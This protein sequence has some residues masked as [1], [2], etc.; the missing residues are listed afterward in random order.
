MGRLQREEQALYRICPAQNDCRQHRAVHHAARPR[1]GKR[2][3]LVPYLASWRSLARLTEATSESEPNSSSSVRQS[4]QRPVAELV[5]SLSLSD[6]RS[7][8]RATGSA[9]LKSPEHRGS[10]GQGKPVRDDAHK[11][12]IRRA[13]NIHSRGRSWMRLPPDQSRTSGSVSRLGE[14]STA[15]LAVQRNGKDECRPRA[16][17][18]FAIRTK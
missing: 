10:A 8:G 13:G 16:A 3:A 1:S 12:W 5:G 2:R 6:G 18:G 11:N 7:L 9:R 17:L 14:T 15:L 4:L